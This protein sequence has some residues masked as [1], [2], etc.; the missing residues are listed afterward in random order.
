MLYRVRR[1]GTPRLGLVFF[2]EIIDSTIFRACDA[3]DKRR[4]CDVTFTGGKFAY[5][6][7]VYVGVILNNIIE[8]SAG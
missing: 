7:G 5:S 6:R 8:N 2:Q 4:L 3:L 1:R